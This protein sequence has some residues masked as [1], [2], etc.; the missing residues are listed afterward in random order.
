MTT[1]WL[2]AVLG[3]ALIML[4]AF[5]V[6]LFV[7]MENED[8]HRM[9]RLEGYSGILARDTEKRVE[10]LQERLRELRA[11]PRL[12]EAFLAQGP[13]ALRSKEE[14]LVSLIPNALRVRLVKLD[15]G[16]VVASQTE[17]LSYAG[18]DLIHEAKR[19]R[20][21]TLLEVHRLGSPE[22]HLAIAA[23]VLDEQGEAVLG[24]VHVSLPMSLLPSVADVDG[25]S[26]H[27]GI[28]QEVAGQVVMV[29]FAGDAGMPS[30]PA[31]RQAPIKGTRL[32]VGAWA[33]G[34]KGLNAQLLLP[35]GAAYLALMAL[36]MLAI[37]L[38]LRGLRRALTQ[39]F[40]QV[41]A[42]V[43]DAV[44][45]KPIRNAQF[46]LA[47]TK[48]LIDVLSGLLR[49]LRAPP[50]PEPRVPEIKPV[51]SPVQADAADRPTADVDTDRT[52][53]AADKAAS[54]GSA[55]TIPVPGAESVPAHIFRVNDIRGLID[56][57]L[58]AELV[59]AIGLA[60]GT[61]AGEAGD[62][63]VIIGR[64]TRPSGEKLSKS[65]AAG[66]RKSGRDVLDLGVVP[67]PLVYFATCF[68]GEASGVMVTASHNPETYNGL[69]VVV[70]GRTLGGEQLVG[71]RERI[72]AGAFSTG[73]GGYEAGELIS[74]YIAYVARDIAIARTLKVVVD[75]G[76][77]TAALV[78]PRLYRALDCDLVELDCDPNARLP[79]GRI[80]DPA[81][82]ECL[83][84]LQQA[85]TS[86]GADLGLAFD[87]DGDRLG[88]V[89]S[90]GKIIWPDRVLM[91]LA[92][93]VLS[94]HPGTDVIF[95]VKS[96][97]HLATEILRH[98]G[99][100]VMWKSG[101]AP[102]KAKLRETG[103]LLAGERSGHIM[104]RE[105]WFGFD[106]ALYSG[107][108]LLEVLAL[109]PRSSAEVFAALPEAIGTAE[110]F[111]PL[112]EGE[113]A[114]IMQSVLEQ[115]RKIE[116]LDLRT[117]DGLR[118]ESGQGWGLVRACNTQPALVFRFEADD[119]MELS[120][121]QDLFRHIMER[122][123][124]ELLLPF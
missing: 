59:Y 66:L 8:A 67:T 51:A 17:S 5:A 80:P 103:A 124:P 20:S 49:R 102:L 76:N 38:P 75:C 50:A 84:A 90:S 61:E 87:S 79:G 111:L 117:E 43:E 35:I 113:S 85:V 63:T 94:R 78:A 4:F 89:D 86:Q 123:A 45:R 48:P 11:D 55:A 92:A 41:A 6:G 93:D 88:V 14:S 44:N 10:S 46:R 82:P 53:E 58:S 70:G 28:Q 81:A 91:L 56:G 32:L 47:E 42:L 73:D 60:V 40:R 23:P 65:L 24:V 21:L 112:A 68:Q 96:S 100:P 99:R 98:G 95:D 54:D 22:E 25:E 119:E 120:R 31:D 29:R 107:A 121:I 16:G 71:L 104:F 83:H 37:W 3:V 72:L 74:D 105:R 33:G 101:H 115:A 97:H 106:D 122:A 109:D 118:A 52:E 77:A 39:D 27:M 13:D 18:L 26:G 57:E 114:P 15:A 9:Q 108:R 2:R 12:H 116:G 34:G 1:Y 7:W 36:V 62:Q 30:G 64:D 110:L 19:R 69:K